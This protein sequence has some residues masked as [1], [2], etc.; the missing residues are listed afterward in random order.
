MSDREQAAG[1]ED[2]WRFVS[3]PNHRTPP[4][5]LK[6]SDVTPHARLARL[7]SGAREVVTSVTH[8]SY[9]PRSLRRGLNYIAR[10]GAL[11]LEDQ[12]GF[13]L[14]GRGALAEL[15]QDWDAA[16][17]LDSRRRDEKPLSRTMI[18]SMPPGVDGNALEAG[19]RATAQA[20]LAPKFDYVWVRHDDTPHPHAHLMVRALGRTGE[21]FTPDRGDCDLIRQTFAA[22]L[23]EHGVVAE[24]T[25]RQVR[26]VTRRS[27]PLMLRKMREAYERGEAAMP[28]TLRLAYLEAAEIAF[29]GDNV[30]RPWEEQ[31]LKAQAHVRARLLEEAA[32]LG[33][34]SQ[35]ADRRLAQDLA[36]FV[37]H[38]PAPDTRRLA[39][40]RG[41]RDLNEVLL[42]QT[43]R[44][45]ERL[46]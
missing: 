7:A 32:R 22:A 9:N 46:R 21:R 19:V 12:D 30:L 6:R 42:H 14:K 29:Q 3:P 8:A 28:R 13:R 33:R 23:R 5:L 38:M 35:A 36:K 40:A 11:E 34:S 1:F 37:E 15:V 4:A 41:L 43:K 16:A 27:E 39:L 2:F 17:Q 18:F 44:G 31:I 20:C 25:R 10:G 45:P 24:A 26:G